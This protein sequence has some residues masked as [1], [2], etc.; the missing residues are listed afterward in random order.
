MKVVFVYLFKVAI[1]KVFNLVSGSFF[2]TKYLFMLHRIS[3]AAFL[4]LNIIRY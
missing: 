2:V 4:G 3:C 1:L